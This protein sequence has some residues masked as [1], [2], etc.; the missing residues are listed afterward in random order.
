MTVG[1][2]S[3]VTL[4]TKSYTPT[5]TGSKQ[6]TLYYPTGGSGSGTAIPAG[7]YRNPFTVTVADVSAPTTPSSPSPANGATKVPT[8]GTMS[9]STSPNDGG[10]SISYDLYLGKTASGMTLHKSG[11]G[12][13]YAYSNLDA[14]QTYF[15][16]VIVYNG[17]G[18][19]TQSPTWSFTTAETAQPS[20][21]SIAIAGG[22]FFGTNTLT[23]NAGKNFNIKVQNTGSSSWTGSFFLKCGGTNWLDWYGVTIAAGATVTLPTKTYTPTS[24]GKKELTLYFQTGGTG[25]GT[26]VEAGYYSN[27][28]TVT[29]VEPT[30]TK[31]ATPDKNT[32]RATDITETSFIASWG[33]VSGADRY[34]INVREVG[35]DYNNPVFSCGISTT[36]VRVSNLTAGT[37]Y[38]FQIR[39]RNGNNSQ[40]RDWSASIPNAVTTKSS[41][42]VGVPS[43]NL[44]IYKVTGFSGATPLVEGS[45]SF[46]SI[47]VANKGK[48]TWT[49]N[50]YLKEGT[51]TI[52][53]WENISIASNFGQPLEF[54]YTPAAAGTKALVLYYQTDGK[55]VETPVKNADGSNNRI[56]FT[57]SAKEVPTQA[58]LRLWNKISC[59]ANINLG[60]S[61]TVEARVKNFGTKDWEGT[62]FIVDGHTVLESKS[63]II[64][65]NTFCTIE[66]TWKPET[67][68]VYPISI[69]F[70]TKNTTESQLVNAN[71]FENPISFKVVGP[72]SPLVTSAKVTMITSGCA[73]EEVNEGDE[74]FYYYRIKD[75]NGQPLKDMR[76]RMNCS[77]S[78]KISS[79]MS[80]PSDEDGYVTLRVATK[81]A[82]AFA[83][84]GEKVTFSCKDVLDKNYNSIAIVKDANNNTGFTLKLHKS[85]S[86]ASALA[87]EN[88][89]SFD[90][91][92]N[93]GVNGEA[94]AGKFLSGDVGLSFPFTA[95]LKWEDGKFLTEIKSETKGKLEG[96]L[97]LGSYVEGGLGAESGLKEST[98]YNWSD[99][100]RTA[101]ALV[102]ALSEATRS[103]TSTNTLRSIMALE[104]WLGVDHSSGDGFFTPVLEKLPTTSGF[105]GVS[106]KWKIK[107]AKLWPF[108][109]QVIPGNLFPELVVPTKY[110]EGKISFSGDLSFKCEPNIKEYDLEKKKMSYGLSRELKAK[111]EGNLS[112]FAGALSPAK[113]N[114][115]NPIPENSVLLASGLYEKSVYGASYSQNWSVTTKEKEMYNNEDYTSLDKLI[116][117]FEYEAGKTFSTE[118]L[119]DYLCP[120]WMEFYDPKQAS[121]SASLALGTK[122]SWKMTSTGKFAKDL[123]QLSYTKPDI[124]GGIFP[125]LNRDK[126][127]IQA[128]LTTYVILQG[129]NLQNSLQMASAHFTSS[130]DVTEAFKLE[131]QQKEG[132]EAKLKLPI[133]KW[134]LFDITIECGLQFEATYY[135]TVSYYSV[136]DKRFLPVVLRTNRTF[137]TAVKEGTE[138]LK[139]K[140]KSAF[141][142]QDQ[143]ELTEEV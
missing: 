42:S 74:V 17:S 19:S 122:W 23:L 12:S 125:A 13:S 40:N 39:A 44:S 131:Q 60:E 71:G 109:C 35:G 132:L 135:P 129:N 52:K 8:S 59:P 88:M 79:I 65:P 93:R 26:P 38:Q 118:K 6:L 22:S 7:S 119:V 137:S 92:I 61:A 49:G 28:F 126:Y 80:E 133:A 107:A 46:C 116:N 127:I 31:L 36:S 21:P 47:S 105:W 112:G 57:V 143:E 18:Q 82:E 91:V 25:A 41:G 11:S 104:S 120:D 45:T 134:G 37:S 76:L 55:G 130:Y 95:S 90:I 140:I 138:F 111:I 3:T 5:S 69:Q 4:P 27:P 121:A 48:S 110:V 98:T 97:K 99:S 75:T 53:K 114:L 32:F 51:T 100:R 103:F 67:G 141:S 87:L 106:G 34:D 136:A 101:I 20:Q 73:P 29:V 62:V 94:K 108:D 117:T 54:N 14:G 96:T 9:W 142:K 81:D 84:R 64:G 16:K 123:L 124:V 86:V 113:T 50:F 58:D 2:G 78:S 56:A 63:V 33:A 68:K 115:W 77:G 66:K 10:S 70:M 43:F 89:E 139:N 1:A 128:P 85:N 24:T 72:N 15:W 83:S 30:T 102:L